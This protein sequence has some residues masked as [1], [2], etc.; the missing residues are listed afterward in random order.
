MLF[1]FPLILFDS[2]F[3]V[4]SM[5]SE[6]MGLLCAVV[7]SVIN[8]TR[9]GFPSHFKQVLCLLI[10]SEWNDSQDSKEIIRKKIRH[11]TKS[12]CLDKNLNYSKIRWSSVMTIWKRQTCLPTTLCFHDIFFST[13]QIISSLNL[14]LIYI[15]LLLNSNFSYSHS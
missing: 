5:N 1:V 9:H 15:V 7:E 2:L 12:S 13:V 4:F 3:V 6:H 10:C 8:L 11:N 14:K